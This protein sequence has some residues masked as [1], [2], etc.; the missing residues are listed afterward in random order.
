LFALSDA[1]LD[2]VVL[3]M[4]AGETA[5]S[6]GRGRLGAFKRNK[7]VRIIEPPEC[8]F[9]EPLAEELGV[10]VEHE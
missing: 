9:L 4:T 3:E 2:D 6:V 7:A 8:G 10:P 1:T 5:R